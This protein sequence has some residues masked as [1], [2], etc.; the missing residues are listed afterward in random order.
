MPSTFIT[1]QEAAEL[2]G[3]P[4]GA[5][6]NAIDKQIVPDRNIES[7]SFIETRDVVTLVMLPFLSELPV[8]QK[9]RVRDWLWTTPRSR[10]LQLSPA[11]VVQRIDIAEQAGR[12]AARYAR[13]RDKWITSDPDI[14]GGEPTIRGSRVGVYMLAERVAHGES[15]QLLDEDFPH[16]PHEARTVAVKYARTHPRRGRPRTLGQ[17]A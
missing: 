15:D 3:L 2:S 16:I 5:V 8:D 14:R 17:P 10:R 1:R 6:K 4:L 7:Q 9:R 13:L 12:D 11:L